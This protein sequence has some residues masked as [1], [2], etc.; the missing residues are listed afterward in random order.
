MSLPSVRPDEREAAG[1]D[2]QQKAATDDL[3]CSTPFLVPLLSGKQ[4]VCFS[5]LATL[6]AVGLVGF[7]SWWQR[8]E[9]NVDAFR[10]AVNCTLLFW[11]TVIPG[12]FVLVFARARAPNRSRP[13]LAGQRVAMVVTKESSE[14]F[15]IVRT[16]LLAMLAQAYPHDTWLADEDPSEDTIEWCARHGVRIST[17]KGVSDYHRPSW[18]RRARCKE[19]NLAYF[20]DH[21]GYA[22]YDF[23]A[24]LDADHVP[25]SGYLEE[26][27]RPFA[28]PKVGY[29][30]APSIC[31]RNANES[32]AARG[33]LYMEAALH[34]P[35]QAG[36]NGGLA[37]LCIGSHYAVRTS[38]LH[39]IGGLGP[40]LAEDHSTT[41]MM[42]AHGWRGVHALDALASGEGPRTFAD[43]A[44]QEYQWARSLTVILFRHASSS[45][46]RLPWRL[47]GQFL[48]AQLWYPLFSLAMAGSVAM[49]I[50][51][52][53]TGR[54]WAN[55][56][57]S[58][59]LLHAAPVTA[60]IL[61]L[62]VW[63]KAK[64][65]LRPHSAT[66]VSWEGLAFLFARWPWSLL[67][68]VSAIFDCVRGRESTFRV[69]PK[70][71]VAD[72][73]APTRVIAPY[74]WLSLMCGLPV[75]LVND[76]SSARGFFVISIFNA[77]VYLAIAVTIVV[78]HARENGVRKSM[79]SLLLRDGPARNRALMF[80]AAVVLL[81][82]GYLRLGQGMDALM[83]RGPEV[84]HAVASE[85]PKIGAYDPDHA[86][87][88]TDGLYYEHIFVSW[89]DTAAS[90]AIQKAQD[91]AGMRNRK[92]MV[93]VEP[94][95]AAGR[96]PEELLKDVRSGAYDNEIDSVCRALRSLDAP[97][98]VRWAQ[99]MES[100]T[101]R[102]PWAAN[103]PSG[104]I[105]AYRHFVD[106][107]RGTS[108][109]LSFIWSPRGDRPLT[110][111]FPGR[112]YAD[113]IGLSV[114]ACQEC[115][116][117]SKEGAESANQILREK[118]ARV[119]HYGLPVIIAE[120]GVEGTAE[121][122]RDALKALR[123]EIPSMHLLTA[124]VYF[125][126]PDSPGVWPFMRTPD[127]QLDPELLK[128]LKSEMVYL[129]S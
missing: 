26:M 82:G 44:T 27:L 40:E 66:V 38:A 69:T 128:E 35:L 80:A 46:R 62:M 50:I 78:A 6:W 102:Y 94:W 58:E 48:F 49:P 84:T 59:Y 121:N 63:L 110:A 73:H 13:I 33:R 45:F 107:C 18:P 86:Y 54:V 61:L 24:Q 101:G 124:V 97:V 29:V 119:R 4:R 34:G 83:W 91:Y 70:T 115:E 127:W 85:P 31:D 76:P 109:L 108:R 47:K 88:L 75:L 16:T 5:V 129:R 106:R 118:Y 89:A 20:Y 42:N 37:P 93:T 52:L 81:G 105:S 12:Y 92:L 87:A 104:Y 95:T 19:G 113:E 21:F 22:S 96:A 72:P 67:G 3:N 74:L 56:S 8:P 17:R 51:A 36:H 79:F 125:N 7:W 114:F 2:T 9:H 10:Y 117:G 103:D 68:V 111:Y 99:E 90:T 55:V 23:V 53:L 122:Q 39:G 57:Y 28:D 65:F 43:M 112:G 98:K 77:V 120:L 25:Q 71:A 30:S 41:L 100:S 116:I 123:E 14:P 126:A 32:W 64:G 15:S 1:R 60:S 11:T